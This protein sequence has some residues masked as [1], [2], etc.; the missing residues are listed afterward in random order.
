M[1]SIEELVDKI[2]FKKAVKFYI[3]I[4]AVLL[5]LCGLAI[6]YIMRDKIEMAINYAKV[7]ENFRHSGFNETLK[8]ELDKLSGSSSDIANVIVTDKNNN[9]VY[10]TSNKL[11]GDN[12]SFVLSPYEPNKRYLQDNLNKDMIYRVT[13]EDNIILNRD[14]ITNHEK[15]ISDIDADFYYEQDMGTNKI[16]LIN[17]IRNR[18]TQEKIYVVRE[19]AEIP[20]AREALKAAALICGI[21]FMIYWVGLAL[22]VFRDSNRKNNNPAL[23]GILVLITNIGGLI[24]YLM[25][26]QSNKIC[27]KCG[28]LQSKGNIY[29]TSC[30]NKINETCHNCGSIITKDDN[31]CSK[32]GSEISGK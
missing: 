6:A 4:S 26:K 21:I 30:G 8:N 7:S 17:F 5:L 27:S 31:F 10:K 23:W 19:A 15:V 22:W 14:Y 29:C 2:N 25:Y 16:D 12:G 13:P 20:Y 9:I 11:V 3:A 24:I 28:S 32:C 18:D 1:R